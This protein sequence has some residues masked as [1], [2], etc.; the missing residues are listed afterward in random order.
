MLF[1]TAFSDTTVSWA[2]VF[3]LVHH[4]EEGQESFK[5]DKCLEWPQNKY[6]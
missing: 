1:Q 3:E 2:Q 4:S 5:S 6:K